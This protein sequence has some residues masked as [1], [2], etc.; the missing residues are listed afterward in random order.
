MIINLE[1]NL[2]RKLQTPTKIII[3]KSFEYLYL[4]GI[5]IFDFIENPKCYNYD[6]DK[7]LFIIIK[8]YSRHLVISII[9]LIIKIYKK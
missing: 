9:E 8:K 2:I 4:L 7:I 5:I 6:D 1:C 3:Y